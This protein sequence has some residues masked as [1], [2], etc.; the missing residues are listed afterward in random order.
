MNFEQLTEST[1]AAITKTEAAEIMGIDPRTVGRGIDEGA[2]PAIKI[3]RRVLIPRLPFLQMLTG[4][5]FH[6]AA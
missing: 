3:G 5:K 4:E 1:R 2:I 6:S